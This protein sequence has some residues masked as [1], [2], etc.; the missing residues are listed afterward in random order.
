MAFGGK[1][2]LATHSKAIRGHASRAA[3]GSPHKGTFKNAAPAPKGAAR[4]HASAPKPRG[5]S[6]AKGGKGGKGAFMGGA[7]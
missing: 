1:D 7:R 5:V 4:M 3:A 6:G 2:R